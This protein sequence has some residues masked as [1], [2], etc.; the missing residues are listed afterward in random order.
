MHD[1]DSLRLAFLADPNSIHTRRWLLW[2][3]ERGHRVHLLDG[4]GTAISPGLHPGISVERYAADRRGELPELLRRIGTHVLHAHYA[5]T[6]GW[7][8]SASGFHPFVVSPWGSDLLKVRP[9]QVRVRWLNRRTL[10]GADLVTVTSETMRRAAIV[11]GARADRIELVQHGVDTSVFRARPLPASLAQRL[12]VA[13]RAVVFSPRAIRPVYRQDVIVEAFA[14]L[15][16]EAALVMTATAADPAYLE[17]VRRRIDT[18][19][20]GERVR[21]VD[22]ISHDEMPDYL[23]LA[24]V[25]A[26]VPESDSFAVTLQEAMACE[27]P[28]VVSD[29]PPAR[30]VLGPIAPQAL[31]P[32]GDVT[33]LASALRSFLAMPP[34]ERARLGAVLRAWVLD[35]GDYDANMARM[36]ALYRRLADR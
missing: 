8:A 31:V 12:G 14:A 7:Q 18:L 29:L 13:G 24:S 5:R 17:E 36:E 33:A 10:R 15:P 11:A 34:V 35:H 2:F 28:L 21:I 23:R 26:S 19:G 22:E 16:P 3:A 4:F 9:I 27:T 6:F 25:V 1:G 32:V 20:L 30:A